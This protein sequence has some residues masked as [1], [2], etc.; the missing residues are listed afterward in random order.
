MS[1]KYY[2]LFLLIFA[3][4]ACSKDDNVEEEGDGQLK[5]LEYRPAPGQFVN[6]NMDCKTQEEANAY[7]QQRLADQLYVS[8]GSFGGYITVKMPQVIKNRKGYDFGVAG[9]PFDNSSEPG[10]V[11]VSEDVNKN[12]KADDSWYELKGGDE[13][14]RGYEVTYSRP[15]S[16]GDIP[17]ED[18]KGNKGVINYLPESHDQMYY[19]AW[20]EAD[21][22]TLTGSML[23]AR[24]KNEHGI[25]KNQP[26]SRGFADNLGTDIE[27]KTDGSYRYN[28]F[29]LDD[30]MDADGK[31]VVLQQ[32]HFVKIQSAIL[33]NV[34]AIGEVSTEVTGFKIF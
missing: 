25:W 30:A 14:E 21:S 22:Y 5:V 11:W 28:Q 26:F 20:V 19:P 32:I 1:N 31:S 15:S 29:E 24:T 17:W 23:E 33:K 6:E 8:L 2:F 16:V 3:F 12:G 27:K 13:T 18:N 4:S 9:N 7:A 34:D 10:V